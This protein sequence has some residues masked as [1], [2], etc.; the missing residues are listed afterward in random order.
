MEN[1]YNPYATL[2]R[3]IALSLVST[4]LLRILSGV[5]DARISVTAI[6]TKSDAARR[7]VVPAD[8]QE[9]EESHFNLVVFTTVLRVMFVPMG[10]A[11]LMATFVLFPVTDWTCHAKALQLMTGISSV[12]YWASNFLFDALVYLTAW[13]A[14]GVLFVWYY[15]VLFVTKGQCAKQA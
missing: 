6:V 7:S 10:T 4:A 14:I 5:P 3:E 15:D 9:I 1:W 12:L 8:V 11:F 13:V 2:S